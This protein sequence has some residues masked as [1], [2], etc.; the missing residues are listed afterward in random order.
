MSP[1]LRESRSATCLELETECCTKTTQDCQ[2]F[3]ESETASL[4]TVPLTE[5]LMQTEVFKGA[6][7]F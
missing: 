3:T 7:D 5:D 4:E 2:V 6:I 1:E